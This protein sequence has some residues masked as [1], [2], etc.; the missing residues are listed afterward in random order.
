MASLPSKVENEV[1]ARDKL[2]D[3]GL[4]ANI[5]NMDVNAIFDV[6]NVEPVTPVFGDKIV[7]H[8]DV[9]PVIDQSSS[10]MGTDEA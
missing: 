1:S 7:D 10:N 5:A 6:G 8:G 4:I 2:V 3:Q 9:G